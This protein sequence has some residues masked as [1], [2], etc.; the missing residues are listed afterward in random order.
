MND[1]VVVSRRALEILVGE[2]AKQHLDTA[3]RGALDEA[4][5]A[6]GGAATLVAAQSVTAGPAVVVVDHDERRCSWRLIGPDRYE[7]EHRVV[8]IGHPNG[9]CDQGCCR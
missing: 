6:L 4:R 9:Y 8:R 3:A 7:C 2:L 1:H 5:F